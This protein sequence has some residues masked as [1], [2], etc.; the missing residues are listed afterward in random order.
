MFSFF[1]SEIFEL[2]PLKSAIGLRISAFFYR[3]FIEPFLPLDPIES[4]PSSWLSIY[5]IMNASGSSTRLD[6][7]IYKTEGIHEPAN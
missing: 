6:F 4:N 2:E 7:N 3:F 1:D 5:E